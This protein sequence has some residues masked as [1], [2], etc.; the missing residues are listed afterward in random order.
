MC[1]STQSVAVANLNLNDV[2]AQSGVEVYPN[3][4]N[5]NF[6]IANPA[7]VEIAQIK[8]LNTVGAVIAHVVPSQV[9]TQYEMNL[10]GIAHGVYLVQIQAANGSTTVQRI[11]VAD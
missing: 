5:G 2:L 1:E 10:N 3:P 11:I 6:F 4:S 7:S 9:L 8:V